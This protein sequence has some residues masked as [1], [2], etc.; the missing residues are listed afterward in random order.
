MGG[1]LL[2]VL[3][4]LGHSL[5]HYHLGF[6]ERL[7]TW[8]YDLRL[9][10]SAGAPSDSPVV[11]IDIDEASLAQYGRWPWPRDVLAAMMDELFERQ[12]VALVAFDVVFAEPDTSSG[13]P[14]LERLADGRLRDHS[15]FQ[16]VLAEL[17]NDLD[18]DRRF[19]RS[20]HRRPAVLG[21]YFSGG[22]EPL[23][24]GRL[25][26]PVYRAEQFGEA[27]LPLIQAGGYGANLALFQQVAPTAGHFIP[28]FD[29]DGR[30]RRVPMLIEYDGGY[31]ESLSL[32]AARMFL[33]QPPLEP[34]LVVDPG[35]RYIALEALQVAA[36]PIPVDMQAIAFIPYVGPERSFPYLS[37]AD[38]V[39]QALPPE[40]LKGRIALV[41]TSAPGLMDLRSTPVGNAYPG[42]EI[43]ANLI[44]GILTNSIRHQPAYFIGLEIVAVVLLGGLLALLL[45]R[46][47]P[48]NSLLITAGAVGLVIAAVLYF[49]EV[50]FLILPVTAVLLALLGVYALD[51]LY[52][53]FVESRA[54]ARIANLFGQY[55]PQRVV[56]ELA[57]RPELAAMSGDAREMT[58]L[59]SDIRDF[60]QIS[61]AMSPVELS[62]FMNAYLS[63]MTEV[64]QDLDGTVDK[65]IGDAIMA[66][67]GAP[68]I[69]GDHA[70][71]T[72]R[73]ALAMQQ[74]TQ[75]LQPSFS[76]R[77]WPVP[78][79]GI[80]I[81]SGTMNVGNMGSSFRR[82][83][84]VLGDAV[85]LAARLEGLTKVYGTAILVGEAT[86]LTT[87]E[88]VFY[89]EI[90]WVQVKGRAG[91]TRIFE[92]LA[93][94]KDAMEPLPEAWSARCERYAEL[95]VAY[96]SRNW[97]LAATRL[98]QLEAM[99]EYPHLLDT[100]KERI[101]VFREQPPPETWNGAYCFDFK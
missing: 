18:H 39:G 44:H 58:V 24:S 1:G 13:L 3:F 25:P 26:A 91:V 101:K 38:V 45:P 16:E 68:L 4:I 53:V 49:W 88:H 72:V 9:L 92:P 76:E 100:F 62:A 65:Y 43:H 17:R 77:G 31:Y 11:I 63:R 2:W 6:I 98:G 69:Q 7:E 28:L 80:G 48:A 37:A 19:A 5:G 21:Y 27:A 54:R 12:Q 67:W 47:G 86:F 93:L 85:N 8:S 40:L 14:V 75:A 51:T 22:H 55:V 89:R 73:G 61:E 30:T 74:A 99:G 56:D 32:A 90:D 42:V 10:A 36:H 71:R 57:D 96:R 82:A 15:E 64:I 52:A 20:L 50:F 81:N 79:V 35:S 60:T 83:Y 34:V 23:R 66:F 59:F 33:G 84:T 41:G 29:A 95:L 94:R 97:D 87:S 70:L 78:V 46:F